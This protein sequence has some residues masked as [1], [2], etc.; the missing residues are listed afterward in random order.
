MVYRVIPSNTARTQS[1]GSEGIQG[2]RTHIQKIW[3][4]GGNRGSKMLGGAKLY[5]MY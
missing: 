3:L 4:G 2:V 1:A 5:I